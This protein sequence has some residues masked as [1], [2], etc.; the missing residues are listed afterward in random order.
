MSQE[1]LHLDYDL[2]LQD[3][4][5]Y[6]WDTFKK[7]LPNVA[8]FWGSAAVICFSLAFIFRDWVRETL[9]LAGI[10]VIMLLI[11]IVMTI[12]SYHQYITYCKKTVADFSGQE[13]SVHF[14]FKTDSDGFECI[15]GN[16]YSFISWNSVSS[17]S[18]EKD[19]F[20]FERKGQPFLIPKSAFY[21]EEQLNFFRRLA[22]NKLGEAKLL[23]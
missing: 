11:P 3:F 7:T 13:K 12:F 9:I 15:S 10:G 4:R 20:V 19:Y 6:W 16:D 2:S 17:I 8:T 22:A 14:T 5:L 18:E 23:N 1:V 21:G